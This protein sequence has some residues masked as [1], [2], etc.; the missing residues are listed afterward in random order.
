M[1]GVLPIVVSFF[2]VLSCFAAETWHGGKRTDYLHLSHVHRGGGAKEAP[3]NT[4]ETFRWCWSNGS[5][6]ECDCRRTKDGVGIMLHDDRLK[7]TGRGIPETLATNSVSRSLTW[8][9]IKDVDVGLYQGERFKGQRVPTIEATFAAMKGNPTWLAMVDE[10]GA[11]PK[12]IAEKAIAAGVQD[13]VYY[14]GA[15][16]AN[17]VKWNEILP[18]GRS[19]L[20]IGAFPKGRSAEMR[21]KVRDHFENVMDQLRKADFKYVTSVSLHTYYDPTDPVDPF[22]LGTDYLRKLIDEFHAHGVVVCS[23]PFAGGDREETYFKLW[24]LGCDG[25]STDYPSVMFEVIR[26]LRADGA[27]KGFDIPAEA[28]D[29][30]G[31]HVQGIAVSADAVYVS[32]MTQLTKFDWSGKVLAT[33]RVVSHTGDVAW[34]NGELYTAVAVYPSRKEGKI[35]VFDKDLRLVRE[36]TIDRTIDGITCLDG[37]LYVGM[38]AKTPPSN[39]PHRVN[40]LGRFDAK[41]LK[42][43]APRQDFDFGY[44]T[45]YGF[46]DIATDGKLLYGAFYPGEKGMPCLAVFDKNGKVVGTAKAGSSTGF[47]FLPS[48]D[49]LLVQRGGKLRVTKLPQVEAR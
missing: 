48:R 21:K 7:R 26:K 40:V 49:G 11:G 28:L 2:A 8:D 30:K 25:F 42:E 32:Q 16:Y 36:T 41:T 29:P 31:G 18:G 14:T 37:V 22:L 23:I 3:D 1:Q 39:E 20:W 9:E 15:S 10:K 12:Y 5:A 17:I 4:L 35:Q 6:V 47:D 44:K 24:E 27:P 45:K 38:G 34:W 46:Q 13:Q 19:L 43:I 33:N